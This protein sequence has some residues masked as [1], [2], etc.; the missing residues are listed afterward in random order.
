[1]AHPCKRSRH[2]STINTTITNGVSTVKTIT[3]PE[4][5]VL[6]GGTDY[7]LSICKFCEI[8]ELVFIMSLI[9]KHTNQFIKNKI[10]FKTLKSLLNKYILNC[11]F[12]VKSDNNNLDN[13]NNNN[14]NE[15]TNMSLLKYYLTFNDSNTNFMKWNGDKIDM[16]DIFRACT[17]R[18]VFHFLQQVKK[19]G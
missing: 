18:G 6:L 8:R 2:T 15:D 17:I 14:N 5:K 3:T 13:N 16:N 4:H 10:I 9:C 1:M 19:L 7:L 12:S 11:D